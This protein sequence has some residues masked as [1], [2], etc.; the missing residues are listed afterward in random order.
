MFAVEAVFEDFAVW[1][2]FVNNWIGIDWLMMCE[3]GDLAVLRGLD[4]ELF[5]VRALVD[6][7]LSAILFILEKQTQKR[8]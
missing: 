3:Y 2:E 1:I 7:N 6:I 4:Q 5:D 8:L